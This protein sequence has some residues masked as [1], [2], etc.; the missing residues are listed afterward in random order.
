MEHFHNLQ[1]TTLNIH[2]ADGSD[3]ERFKQKIDL[4]ECIKMADKNEYK[5]IDLE[6]EWTEERKIKRRSGKLQFYI[7]TEIGL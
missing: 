1:Q 6:S 2:K 7:F 3:T 5:D 4:N